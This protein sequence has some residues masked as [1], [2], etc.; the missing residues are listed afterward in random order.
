M[1]E[2]RVAAFKSSNYVFD[3]IEKGKRYWRGGSFATLIV[4]LVE[5]GY[6][7]ELSVLTKTIDSKH[8]VVVEEN[9]FVVV[10]VVGGS[11]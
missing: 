5:D 4:K 11:I 2:N 3:R 10:S 8:F 7:N 6:K 9:G 1:V